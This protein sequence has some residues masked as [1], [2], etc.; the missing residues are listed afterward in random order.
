V[1]IFVAATSAFFVVGLL[2]IFTVYL[3]RQKEFEEI[4]KKQKRFNPKEV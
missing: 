4:T 3:P 2:A 1:G